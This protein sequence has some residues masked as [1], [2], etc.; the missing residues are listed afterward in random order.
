MAMTPASGTDP[1]GRDATSPWAIPAKGWIDVLKRTWTEA[2][3]DPV[4][5][6]L[7]TLRCSPGHG[8]DAA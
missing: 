2:T 6:V 4:A 1:R 7:A 5:V 3:G 8:A